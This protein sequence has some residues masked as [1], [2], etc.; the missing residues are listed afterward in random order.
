[1]TKVVFIAP[2]ETGERVIV[3]QKILRI[4]GY[5]RHIGHNGSRALHPGVINRL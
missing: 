3:K 2:T 1:M 4:S 5:L